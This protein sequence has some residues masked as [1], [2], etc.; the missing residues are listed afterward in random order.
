MKRDD[1]HQHEADGEEA[2]L[3]G[4]EAVEFG[5]EGGGLDLEDGDDG[6]QQH[7][8]EEDPVEVAI[9]GE[10]LHALSSSLLRVAVSFCRLC[11]FLSL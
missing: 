2:D 1:E 4:V 11:V 3:L 9:G 7:E 10:A 6:E 8:A 5:V